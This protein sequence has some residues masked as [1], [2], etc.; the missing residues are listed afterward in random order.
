MD[1]FRLSAVL[2]SDVQADA[3]IRQVGRSIMR[4]IAF[5]RRHCGTD[6]T[7]GCGSGTAKYHLCLTAKRG[8][9]GD[10]SIAAA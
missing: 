8:R 6:L 4:S 10:S 2:V 3:R 5:R 7:L 9:G 1:V